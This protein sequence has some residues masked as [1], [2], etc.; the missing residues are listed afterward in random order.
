MSDPSESIPT[1]PIGDGGPGAEGAPVA[2]MYPPSASNANVYFGQA[3]GSVSLFPGPYG[4]GYQ[5]QAPAVGVSVTSVSVAGNYILWGGT[6]PEGGR[7]DACD[8]GNLT[9]VLTTGTPVDVQGDGGAWYWG[10]NNLE[11]FPV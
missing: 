1:K 4:S 7:V 10:D 2:A 9:S 5:V 3:N 6:T 11:K 8:N